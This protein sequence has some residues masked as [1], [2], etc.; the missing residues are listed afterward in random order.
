MKRPI[1]LKPPKTTSGKN[2]DPDNPPWT[3]AKLGPPRVRVG[4]GPQKAPTKVSTTIRLDRDVYEFFHSQGAGYQ[5]RIN[6]ALREVVKKY[7][8][9]PSSGRAKARR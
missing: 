6:E 4:R 1:T 3:E 2:L 5:V 7:L 9:T 8:T